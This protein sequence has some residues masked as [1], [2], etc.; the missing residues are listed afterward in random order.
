MVDSDPVGTVRVTRQGT[1]ARVMLA[2]PE[3]RNA[4]DPG[5]IAALTAAFAAAGADPGVRVILL[6]GD[7]P[8][9]CAGADIAYMR[10]I[11]AAGR[12]ANIDD[13]ARLA[14]LFLA[15]HHC[16]KP[17]VARVQGAAY[18]GAVGLVAAA[19][20][21]IAAHGTR[22]ALSE[23]RLGIAPSVIAPFVIRRIGV[24]A[25]TE[26]A[27]TGEVFD[28]S[29]AQ[30]IG[31]IA[32]VAPEPELDEVIDGRIAALLAAA[33]GA[34]AAVKR[35]FTLVAGDPAAHR[36]ATAEL[37]ADLRASDEGREGLAAFMERRPPMWAGDTARPAE[38][39]ERQ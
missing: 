31:L 34:Q 32:G 7:G 11:A 22:F 12:E 16:P 19:D 18:G 2:R 27:L 14:D 17:V 20:I 3:A 23:T 1:I 5:M 30:A 15:V 35:L 28:A 13:A 10:S 8:A 29:R 36:T 38:S 37:I 26:L 24:T 9:F 21:A 33:P 25:A 6:G 4:L 39:R